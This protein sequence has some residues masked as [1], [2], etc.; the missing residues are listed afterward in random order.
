MLERPTAAASFRLHHI[1]TYEA[2]GDLHG[3]NNLFTDDTA[4]RQL[5]HLASK[6]AS[7]HLVRAW[8]RTYGLPI[9]HQLLR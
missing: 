5:A 6:A 8:H 3:V 1:S 4:T 2:Y 9:Y 7:D